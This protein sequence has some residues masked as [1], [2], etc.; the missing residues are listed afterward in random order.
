MLES[1]GR[2]GNKPVHN[3]F[4]NAVKTGA[5]I[6]GVG[7]AAGGL[8]AA[9]ELNNNTERLNGNFGHVGHVMGIGECSTSVSS[10]VPMSYLG[11]NSYPMMKNL[12]KIKKVVKT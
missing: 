1:L 4:N 7:A 2:T 8:Y 9:G 3:K 10:N 6:A 11:N 12:E 5:K